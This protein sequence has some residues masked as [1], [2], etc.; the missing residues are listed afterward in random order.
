MLPLALERQKT[1]YNEF[2]PLQLRYQ[3]ERQI[4]VSQPEV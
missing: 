1:R 3:G 4:G 2:D